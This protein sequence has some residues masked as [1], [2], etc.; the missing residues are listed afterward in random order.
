MFCIPC[1]YIE[2][3]VIVECIKSIYAYFPNEKIVVVDSNS[4]NKAYFSMIKDYVHDII[5]GNENYELGA[6]LLVYKKY[7]NEEY[8][9]CFQDSIIFTSSFDITSFLILRY[10]LFSRCG[11]LILENKNLKIF[12][13]DDNVNIGVFGCNFICKN[14]IMYFIS[15][16]FKNCLPKT[17]KDSENCERI[18]GYIFKNKFSINIENYS[19][20]GEHIDPFCIY[21]ETRMIKKYLSRQ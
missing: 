20:Q 7:P 6:Y 15:I 9:Q 11:G 1:K 10:F 8:Y 5:E 4:D 16:F 2:N 17:K 3:C 19:I 18:L 13:I 21:E 12:E 14:E